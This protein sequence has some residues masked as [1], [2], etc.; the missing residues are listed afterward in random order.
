MNITAQI[1]KR[2]PNQEGWSEKLSWRMSRYLAHRAGSE[3]LRSRGSF[4]DFGCLCAVSSCLLGVILP[5]NSMEF[6]AF[7]CRVWVS[8][9]H[10]W[11][12]LLKP[13][14][15]SLLQRAQRDM[16]TQQIKWKILFQ[17]TSEDVEEAGLRGEWRNFV[18]C[19]CSPKQC[20]YELVPVFTQNGLDAANFLQMW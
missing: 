20:M 6:Q 18:F 1:I 11:P 10:C 4:V 16:G 19:V 9:T 8:G 15:L 17:S 5:W 7:G 2:M 3:R 14:L 12:D 13:K